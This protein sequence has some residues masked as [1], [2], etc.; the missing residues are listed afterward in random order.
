MIRLMTCF[1]VF[2]LSA[3]PV[4]SL[5]EDKAIAARQLAEARFASSHCPDLVLNPG[6]V[7][8]I[9]LKFSLDPKSSAFRNFSR[10]SMLATQAF[11]EVHGVKAWCRQLESQYG[12]KGSVNPGLLDLTK[13]V[14]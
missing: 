7:S 12:P 14:K 13:R 8:E 3:G 11:R 1:A 4:L 5:E 9:K 10:E 6:K 2:M